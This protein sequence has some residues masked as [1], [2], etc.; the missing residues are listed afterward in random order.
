MSGLDIA[1]PDALAAEN[2]RLR[3]GCRAAERF[4]SNGIEYGMIR[5][6]DPDLDDPAH[7]TL[8]LL[9]ALLAEQPVA[10]WDGEVCQVCHRG[11]SDVWH[12]P[13]QDWATVVSA[14]GG[15]MQCTACYARQAEALGIVPQCVCKGSGR[16]YGKDCIYCD[17][18]GTLPGPTYTTEAQP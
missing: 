12:A 3:E 5:M 8:P 6:P 2:A 11:Y 15:G 13:D 9:R 18:S 14:E 4:I 10:E 1:L 17:G 16:S 7:K